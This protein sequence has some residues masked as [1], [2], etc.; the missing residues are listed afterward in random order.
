MTKP[1]S[2]T[3]ASLKRAI[4]AAREAGLRVTG[5]QPDGTLVIEG[6]LAPGDVVTHND[7]PPS[8]KWGRVEA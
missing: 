4:T 5:I 3:K 1:L 2:F 6:E 7:V 8:D